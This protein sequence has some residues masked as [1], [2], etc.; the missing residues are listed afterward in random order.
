MEQNREPIKKP[1]GF[2]GG[3]MI[4]NPPANAGNTR[5]QLDP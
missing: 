5:H 1:M 4:K 2:V 3:A